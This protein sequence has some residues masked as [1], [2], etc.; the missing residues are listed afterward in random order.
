[1]QISLRS[2]MIAGV[3]AVAATAVVVTPITQPDLTALPRL[4]GAV[5]LAALVNP[6]TSLTETL[7]Y[8]VATLADGTPLLDPEDLFWPDSFYTADFGTL[9]APAYFGWVPDLAN[10]FSFGALSAV[11]NNLS[12]YTYAGLYAPLALVGGVAAAAFNAP[13]AIVTAAQLALA[14]DIEGAI[15]ELQTQIVVPIQEGI[16]GALT[17]LSYILDNVVANAQTALFEAVP[18]LV[19]GLSSALVGG[20]AYLVND[21]IATA[22]TVVTSISSGDLEGAWNAAIDGLIGPNGALGN[23]VS[24]TTGIGIVE[25]VEYE[26]GPVLTVTNPSLRSVVTSEAQRLGDFSAN[27]DGGILNDPFNPAPEEVTPPAAAEAAGPDADVAGAV[28]AVARPVAGAGADAG[29]AD[30][31]SAGDT[32]GAGGSADEKTGST[33]QSPAESPTG[34]SAGSSA[35]SPAE[36][37]DGPEVSSASAPAE[38]PA[39]QR[40]ARKAA[41][42]AAEG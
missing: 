11:I 1:M 29:T 18:A 20:V 19:N 28:E 32:A 31:A 14:G 12:G 16:G 27:G 25:E 39:K 10:Q 6:V 9:Y 41:K 7:D 2:Q 30:T 21:L 42:A 33:A 8:T 40:S 5:E 26:E 22:T 37:A 15:A 36:A 17:G 13:F 35:V 24:L 3:A 23:T 34:S 38:K 4:S